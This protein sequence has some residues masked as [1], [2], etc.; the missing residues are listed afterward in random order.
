MAEDDI[1]QLGEGLIAEVMD[2][3]EDEF[4]YYWV[5]TLPRRLED[6]QQADK[7]W[8]EATTESIQKDLGDP[9]VPLTVDPSLVLP[10]L[11]YEALSN[12]RDREAKAKQVERKA[13]QAQR[14]ALSKSERSTAAPVPLGPQPRATN[15]L[16]PTNR[17][18]AKNV[19]EP[20][21][22]SHTLRPSDCEATYKAFSASS[23]ASSTKIEKSGKAAAN[24]EP[25]T[26]PQLYLS[27]NTWSEA[28]CVPAV[29]PAKKLFSPAAKKPSTPLVKK[30]RPEPNDEHFETDRPL[31]TEDVQQSGETQDNLSNIDEGQV[32]ED[33][34]EDE[35][36]D[37]PNK[38]PV[39]RQRK[40]KE[41]TWSMRLKDT[42]PLENIAIPDHLQVLN[43][44]VALLPQT[45][46]NDYQQMLQE[47]GEE[48]VKEKALAAIRPEVFEFWRNGRFNKESQVKPKCLRGSYANMK[49]NRILLIGGDTSTTDPATYLH[50]IWTS[51]EPDRFLLYGGQTLNPRSRVANH[52]DPHFRERYPSLH[53]FAME[54]PGSKAQFIVLA[55]VGTEEYPYR[56]LIQNILEMW[57]CLMFFTLLKDDLA[58]YLPKN[59]RIPRAMIGLNIAL[60]LWQGCTGRQPTSFWQRNGNGPVANEILNRVQ[61]DEDENPNH[62]RDLWRDYR[63][64]LRKRFLMFRDSPYQSHR[65][66]YWKC[67]RRAVAL[68]NAARIANILRK[69]LTSGMLKNVKVDTQAPRV[70]PSYLVILWRT[71]VLGLPAG[72]TLG[73]VVKVRVDLSPEGQSHPHVCATL[74]EDDDPASRLAVEVS[75]ETKT[76]EKRRLWLH[77]QGIKAVKKVNTLVDKLEGVPE[78]VIMK[79]ARRWIAPTKSSGLKKAIYTS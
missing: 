2:K 46:R 75:G 35:P 14:E 77:T 37:E 8:R 58:K 71:L 44:L 76:G 34:E 68:A 67:K 32:S 48:W 41:E 78:E 40:R 45:S 49:H 50:V 30:P 70:T 52:E 74:A 23:S 61:Q 72:S 57:A 19:I 11:F 39:L 18:V 12:Y 42:G 29:T 25:E 47:K 10:V 54:A 51:S 73:S 79:T 60:P 20:L 1:E 28:S 63:R 16:L 21:F 22:G 59:V 15:E 6:E 31:D 7:N 13:N 62:L 24:P 3:L 36:E 26:R 27:A 38:A 64:A 65:D 43:N 5:E 17:P 9:L 66:Y 56:D 33:S 69:L 4:P 53:Y 55:N